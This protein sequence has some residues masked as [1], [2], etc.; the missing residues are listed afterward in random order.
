MATTIRARI[1][2]RGE[3]S[4][5]KFLFFAKLV[6]QTVRGQFFLFCQSQMD[7]KLVCQTIGVAPTNTK[8]AHLD[9]SYIMNPKRETKLCLYHSTSWNLKSWTLRDKQNYVHILPTL[10]NLNQ[11][12]LRK[13]KIILYSSTSS[14][15][16]GCAA[17]SC[18]HICACGVCFFELGINGNQKF[19]FLFL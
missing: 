15:T 12:T 4:F 1:Y 7:A 3:V 9:L 8:W 18:V 2:T 11:E 19:S 6:C 10:E 14:Y 16:E 17:D 13:N 5:A